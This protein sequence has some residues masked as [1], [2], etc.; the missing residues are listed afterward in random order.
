M[1]TNPTNT[2]GVGGSGTSGVGGPSVGPGGGGGGI[3]NN[4]IITSSVRVPWVKSQST[5]IDSMRIGVQ[6]VPHGIDF[7]I[8]VP[9]VTW[10]VQGPDLI[11]QPIAFSIETLL[12]IPAADDCWYIED[13]APSGTLSGFIEFL[14]SIVPS[15]PTIPGPLSS[16]V[17]VPI[18][19]VA[20][21]TAVQA[22]L[23]AAQ[24]L[25]TQYGG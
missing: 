4:W 16:T 25:L 24:A 12:D 21:Y 17:I 6:T 7:I 19:Q 1:A 5:V 10:Q 18:G 14:V 8:Q 20:N 13:A 9:F 11:A 22:Q 23:Q 15:S 2:P 3:V